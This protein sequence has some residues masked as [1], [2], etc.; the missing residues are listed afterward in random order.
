MKSYSI[1]GN[2]MQL[3]EIVLASDEAVI[4]EAGSLNYMDDGIRMET[5]LGD[6][7]PAGS[8]VMGA[9]K[10]IGARLLTGESLFMT[11]FSNISGTDKKIAFAAPHAGAIRPLDLGLLGGEIIAQKDAFLCAEIGVSVGI[12]FQKKIGAM[13]FGGEGL[14]MERLKGS[15]TAFIHAGGIFTEKTLSAG[16]SVLVDTGC[17]VA[18][19][20][21]VSFDIQAVSGVKSLL[22]GGEGIFLAKLSGPGK[23]WIQS[24]PFGRTIAVITNEIMQRL[25]KNQK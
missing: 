11:R 25:P 10:G 18:Y 16:E 23:L 1:N 15:G 9:I 17:V 6:G 4:A 13:F 20:P 22:F 2:D 21:S 3:V 5:V 24:L 8:G 19:Q 14:I 12:A 7:S